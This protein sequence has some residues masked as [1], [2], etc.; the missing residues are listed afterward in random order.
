MV[1]SEVSSLDAGLAVPFCKSAVFL[2][3]L[4]QGIHAADLELHLD[5]PGEL[6]LHFGEQKEGLFLRVHGASHGGEQVGVFHFNSVLFVQV[7]SADESL[8]ELC[9]EVERA[10][11]KGDVTADRLAAGKSADGLVDNSLEDRGGKVLLGSPLV[12]QRLDVGFGKN[13]AARS[14]SIKGRVVPGIFVEAGGV[15]LKKRRHLVD[16]GACA[17]G[18]DSVH[19]LLHIAVFE[20][21]DLGVFTA[22]FDGHIGQ[23]RDLFQS[24]G[25]RDYLLYKGHAEIIGE[26]QTS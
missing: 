14:D 22:Q 3:A 15:G 2:L 24:R 6:L 8:L 20:V 11:Q 19:T 26:R 4:E 10:S 13:A 17:A 23:G 18:T 21:D 16:K 7:Q 1:I 12:D 9:Q 5:I 25:N